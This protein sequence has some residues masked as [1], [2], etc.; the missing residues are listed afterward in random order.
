MY[1]V[2]IDETSNLTKHFTWKT[3]HM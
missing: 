3:F 2:L 1:A